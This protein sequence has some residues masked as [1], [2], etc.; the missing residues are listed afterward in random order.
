MRFAAFDSV[1]NQRRVESILSPSGG[2]VTNGVL[3][4]QYVIPPNYQ[5]GQLIPRATTAINPDY[6]PRRELQNDYVF[7]FDTGPG[8]KQAPRGR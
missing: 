3:T 1:D 5:P 6:Q 2:T 4:P 8:F 7:N